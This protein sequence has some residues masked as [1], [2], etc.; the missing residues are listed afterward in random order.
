MVGYTRQLYVISTDSDIFC[1]VNGFLVD[2]GF[3]FDKDI[4]F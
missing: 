1:Q 3:I 2:S 4:S